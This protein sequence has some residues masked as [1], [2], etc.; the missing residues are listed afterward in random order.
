MKF[1]EIVEQASDFLQRKKRLTYRALKRE[2]DLDD[3][4][5]ADLKDELVKAAQVARDED[6]EVLV[7][8]GGEQGAKSEERRA[9]KLDEEKHK[10]S[11]PTEAP[12]SLSA[13]SQAGAERRQ[14]TVMFCDLVGSTAL[15]T[16]LDPEELRDLVRAYQGTCAA[17]I[18]RYEGHSAQYLG[19]GLLVY[20]GYPVAHKMMPCV[21]CGRD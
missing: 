1:S 13:A 10:T 8:A 15:S 17:V 4:A 7:W 20:F 16:Q 6:G 18:S 19:D 2:F 12:S 14:L 11:H 5:L 3:E 21:P 9:K